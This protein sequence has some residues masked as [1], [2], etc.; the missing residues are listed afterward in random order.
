MAKVVVARSPGEMEQLKSAWQ[1]LHHAGAQ[2]I[3]QSFEFNQL[4]AKIFAERE[5]A[6]VIFV[7]TENG[8]AIIP[9][10][11][12]RERV[13]LLGEE[14]FD[15]RDVLLAGDREALSLAWLKVFEIADVARL[16]FGMKGVPASS[17]GFDKNHFDRTFFAN[18][19]EV[20]CNAAPKSHPRLENRMRRLRAEGAEVKVYS[21]PNGAVVR[22]ILKCKA[23]QRE[24]SL[25]CDAQRLEMVCAMAQISGERCEIFTIENGS[26]LVAA[27]ITFIDGACRRMYTIYYDKA[28]A[29][30]SPGVS[31]LHEV[32]KTSLN[33]GVN[34]DL[35][36]GEQAYKMRFA[37]DK[38]PLYT[39]GAVS[40]CSESR[41]EEEEVL[42]AA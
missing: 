27:L 26:C 13:T 38:K 17:S 21:G 25:F 18:A 22:N 14:M 29:R 15:Y 5:A 11:I 32:I 42:T 19:P 2:T 12:A 24:E 9:A 1:T 28:W 41:K 33:M 23:V 8:M 20:K 34:V 30:Y 36:T 40:L 31:L 7:E 39:L 16:P 10:A 35:M 4:A 6:C 37:T 3:F